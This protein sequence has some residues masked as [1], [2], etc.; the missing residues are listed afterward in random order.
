MNKIVELC[1]KVCE[2]LSTPGMKSEHFIGVEDGIRRCAATIRALSPADLVAALPKDEPVVHEPEDYC[3]ECKHINCIPGCPSYAAPS[4]Q[5]DA[6]EV[7][8]LVKTLNIIASGELPDVAEIGEPTDY[9]RRNAKRAAALL[10]KLAD[11]KGDGH[12]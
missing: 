12:E 1:A 10:A 3:P 7:R 2:A 4:A 5:P 9:I 8:E 11:R 6:E